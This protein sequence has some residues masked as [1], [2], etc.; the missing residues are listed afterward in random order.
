MAASVVSYPAKVQIFQLITTL[1]ILASSLVRCF[2]PCKG[3]NFSANHNSAARLAA[4]SYVV[5]YPAKVQIFQLIT[6]FWAFFVPSVGCF[7]P[8][9]GTNF[10]ANHNPPLVG[11]SGVLVVSYPAKVQ[12]F[13]LITTPRR[14]RYEA[15]CC[16]LPCKGTIFSANHN[17]ALKHTAIITLFLALQR[18]KFFGTMDMFRGQ[19]A[20]FV[21]SY[22]PDFANA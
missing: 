7:L 11:C 3:T 12:I 10:S 21:I 15:L 13:Q 14:S 1:I 19:W 5:S 18:Y 4:V 6:T 2:L 17:N 8:C 9:K 22:C 20:G 16:F